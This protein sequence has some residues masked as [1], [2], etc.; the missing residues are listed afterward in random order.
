[1]RNAGQEGVKSLRISD[2]PSETLRKLDAI[3]RIDAV[4]YRAA[5]VRLLCDIAALEL[6]SGKRVLC[7][8][9]LE[10]LREATSYI[11]DLWPSRS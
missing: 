9:R 3:T 8:A 2:I 10:E 1:V 7:A 5:V 4:V 11:P 6:A